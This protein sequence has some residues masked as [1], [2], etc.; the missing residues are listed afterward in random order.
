[1]CA[2]AM[3]RAVV[4]SR[5]EDDGLLGREERPAAQDLARALRVLGRHEVRMRARGALGGERQHLRRER[6]DDAL[7]ARSRAGA[8]MN[9]AASIASR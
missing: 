5:L 1:M 7:A 6:A 4:G 8:A 2:R 3:A 9:G